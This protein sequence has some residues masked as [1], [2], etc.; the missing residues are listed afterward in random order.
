MAKKKNKS[1]KKAAAKKAKRKPAKKT[2]R[3]PAKVKAKAKKK[4]A[5]KAKAKKTTTSRTSS[6]RVK[7]LPRVYEYEIFANTVRKEIPTNQV[8][9]FYCAVEASDVGELTFTVQNKINEGWIPTGGV[10]RSN[11]TFVQALIRY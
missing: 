3:K 7:G 9:N 10:T 6:R 4:P 11:D 1:K 2:A 8:P 5:R